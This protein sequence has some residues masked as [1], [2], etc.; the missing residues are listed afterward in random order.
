[1]GQQNLIKYT[2]E[3][4]P[5]KR[6]RKNRWGDSNNRATMP[7]VLTA[8]TSKMS[9]TQLD[10]YIAIVRIEEISR[11]LRMGDIFPAGGERSPSPE[12]VYNTEGKRVNTREYRY[13][14]KLEDERSQLIESQVETNP[15]YTPPADYRK[16]TRFSDKYFLPVKE[17]P[18][19]NF[20]GLLIGPRGNTLK[21]IESDSGCKIS[22]RGK[23]SVKEGKSREEFSMPGS[24][25][26]L[27]AYVVSD[28]VEKVSKGIK[29]I[30]DI[31]NQ[32][33]LSPESHNELKRL[34]LRE[35]AALNGTLREEDEAGLQTCPNCGL[36]GHR[37]WECTE[38]KNITA[39]LVCSICNGFG[40]IARDCMFANNPEALKA[41]KE[42]DM[43]L[44]SEY[45]RLMIELGESGGQFQPH[46]GTAAQT[47]PQEMNTPSYG[48]PQPPYMG[49]TAQMP[50]APFT[51]QTSNL[52]PPPPNPHLYP[53]PQ[54]NA[55]EVQTPASQN[56]ISNVIPAQSTGTALANTQQYYSGSNP[57]LFQNQSHLPYPTYQDHSTEKN[58]G[59]TLPAQI[60]PAKPREQDD[61]NTRNE[62][63]ENKG[64]IGGVE[65]VSTN[66]SNDYGSQE[67][68]GLNNSSINTENLNNQAKSN[69]VN[70]GAPEYPSK[71]YTEE[72]ARNEKPENLSN[73]VSI[74][75]I[76]F[77]KAQVNSDEDRKTNEH[78]TKPV[79]ALQHSDIHLNQ[80]TMSLQ[81][82][83]TLSNTVNYRNQIPNHQHPQ[84]LQ[85]PNGYP[86]Q[87][88]YQQ[89]YYGAPTG[90]PDQ[91]HYQNPA[92]GYQNYQNSQ[93]MAFQPAVGAYGVPM[94]RPI[95]PAVH[96]NQYNHINAFGTYPPFNQ[97]GNLDQSQQSYQHGNG[98]YEQANTFNSELY[99]SQAPG[100]VPQPFQ[101]KSYTKEE[102]EDLC[103]EFGIE[104]E[105]DTTDEILES[106][107]KGLSLNK[108]A[109]PERPQLKVDIPA[110]RYDLL[111]FEGISRALA[112]FL[113]KEKSPKYKLSSPQKMEELHVTPETAQVRPIVVSA[114]MR[115]VT[116][117]EQSYKSFIDLQEKLHANICRKRLLVSVGT[118]DLDTIEGPFQY[119]ARPPTEIEFIPLNKTKSYNAVDLMKLYESDLHLRKYLHIIRDS[120]VYP[121][122][123]DKNDTV[124]SLP[125]I[126]NGEHSKITL[127]TKN[128]FIEITALD[129]T[130]ANIVL[131]TIVAMFSC[132]CAE[133]YVIEPVKVIYPDGREVITPDLSEKVFEADSLYI[134]NLIGV[135]MT[136]EEIINY[137]EKMCLRGVLGQH[138]DA[139]PKDHPVNV[140]IEPIE[141]QLISVLVPP[142]RAD[143]LHQVDIIE[144]IAIAYGYNKIPR[145]MPQISTV[146]KPTP[147]N[148]LNSLLRREVALSGWTEVLSLSLCSHDESF[149]LLQ[150]VDDGNEA[151]VLAN[152]KTFE[153]QVCRSLLLPGILKT[154]REN[155]SHSLPFKLFEVSDVILKDMNA[156]PRL[157]RNER[158]FCAVYSNQSAQFQVVLGLLDRVMEML[159]VPRISGSASK[160]SYGYY[161]EPTNDLHTYLPGRSAIVCLKTENSQNPIVLGSIGVIHPNVLANFSLDF[162][163]SSVE[164]NIEPFV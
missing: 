71:Q 40:H 161:L 88:M 116:F 162:P 104:L 21:K 159:D 41:T 26:E 29:V 64:V 155:R 36:P 123:T 53:F 156:K 23:G 147:L 135:D 124:L 139:L 6:A 77:V 153:Y 49:G 72:K 55:S 149:K 32:T 91:T 13:R 28:S 127:N 131:N 111:C 154:I 46:I 17:N 109:V 8:L 96:N 74:G 82:Q 10:N 75:G 144:D 69:L 122:V 80:N 27:H 73:G 102:F 54:P 18:E 160:N 86:H 107:T 16:N 105:E 2:E 15:E 81:H 136:N 138:K 59:N 94:Q 63:T 95:V 121:L 34:Q 97:T 146:G 70:L 52:Q 90:Y 118:H 137:L 128:I 83:K 141:E 25:E 67:P 103:F 78:I 113:Q 129:N 51:T 76:Q 20:I 120:P 84:V 89:H 126:I 132:Y 93:P 30:K 66:A 140:G 106:A 50:S 87:N 47:Q 100:S 157:S 99:N 125:P 101:S 130:K 92:Y 1:M 163:C 134:K 114:I 151:V 5:R 24:D 22:I 39:T 62:K 38:R 65:H 117:T 142:T 61:P 14:K 148:K 85:H 115:N 42:R 56:P 143:I 45:H 145:R 35:L 58:L 158:R 79:E 31:V 119:S 133:K 164:I 60:H 11:K 152:P 43:Q 12:P 110:N 98:F 4:T 112:I 37:R 19:I 57:A 48:Y 108:Q 33:I 68:N 3:E 44:N 7:S 150:R 9:K